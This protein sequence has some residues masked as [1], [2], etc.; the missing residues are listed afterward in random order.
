MFTEMLTSLRNN[1]LPA[2]LSIRGRLQIALIKKQAILN[3][4]QTFRV[5]DPKI[6]PRAD[7]MVWAAVLL[8]D[9]DLFDIT[10]SILLTEAHFHSAQAQTNGAENRSVI[11]K[12]LEELVAIPADTQLK[13]TINK[14]IEKISAFNILP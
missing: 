6:N 7:H 14:S 12:N 5:A 13:E 4:P 1:R 2:P 3:L 9:Q 8:E 11:K 10:I